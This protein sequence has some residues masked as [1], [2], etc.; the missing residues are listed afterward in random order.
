MWCL[1]CG[2]WCRCDCG[3]GC[4]RD[5]CVVWH[6]ENPSVSFKS[7]RVYIQNVTVYAGN[8]RTCFFNMCAC[9]GYTQRRFERTHRD[10]LDGHTARWE[11]VIASSSFQN[12]P[13]KGY[14]LALEV[15]QR[16]P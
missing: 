14:H 2:L 7:S 12:L 10:V 6:A 5:V 4:G 3:C 9:C 1:W 13:T 15:H 16:N 8:T 11:G